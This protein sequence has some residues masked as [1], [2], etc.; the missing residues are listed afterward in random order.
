MYSLSPGSIVQTENLMGRW[1]AFST[2]VKSRAGEAKEKLSNYIKNELPDEE[3][4][5]REIY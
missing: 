2:Q 3:R 4:Y 5:E 1:T